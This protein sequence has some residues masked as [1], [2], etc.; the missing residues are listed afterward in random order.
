MQ[1]IIY[2]ITGVVNCFIVALQFL[3]IARALVSWLPMGEDSP[4][5]RFLYTITEP[6]VMPVRMVLER[7]ESVKNMPI[8]ISFFVAMMLL[9][10]IQ[11]MLPNVV[12]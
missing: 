6:V 4:I 3:M 2:V 9:I 11:M 7:F 5:G 12:V 1:Q 10:V 8:D